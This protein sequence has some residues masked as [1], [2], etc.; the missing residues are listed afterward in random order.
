MAKH[1]KP[2]RAKVSPLADHTDNFCDSSLDDAQALTGCPNAFS[3]NG[4]KV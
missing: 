1:A 3:P 4:A 2:I